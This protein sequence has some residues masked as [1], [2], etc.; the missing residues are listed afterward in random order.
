MEPRIK[1]N[2]ERSGN[3]AP[4]FL[5]FFEARQAAQ[6]RTDNFVY[7]EFFAVL[8]YFRKDA[9]IYLNQLVSSRVKKKRIVV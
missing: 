2:D 3:P 6:K 7:I 1:Q 8:I 9:N 4:L 5:P